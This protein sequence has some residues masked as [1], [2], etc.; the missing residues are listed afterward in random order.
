MY[1]LSSWKTAVHD[2]RTFTLTPP[3]MYSL[4]SVV[5]LKTRHFRRRVSSRT[6]QWGVSRWRDAARSSRASPSGRIDL[7]G[8]RVPASF[9]KGGVW[10]VRPGFRPLADAVFTPVPRIAHGLCALNGGFSSTPVKNTVAPRRRYFRI[11]VPV[12]AR[13]R[14]TNIGEPVRLSR[15]VISNHSTGAVLLVIVISVVTYKR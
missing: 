7:A 14:A 4:A 15:S 1:R 3:I 12:R 11:R 2:L 9:A 6:D 8:T 13:A 10:I 5:G